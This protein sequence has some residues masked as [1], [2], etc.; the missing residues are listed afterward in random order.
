M[1]FNKTLIALSLAVTF[2][3]CTTTK[4]PEEK[5]AARREATEARVKGG[6]NYEMVQQS[7]TNHEM[8]SNLT[9]EQW[10]DVRSSSKNR[11][12]KLFSTLGTREWSVAA[13]DARERLKKKPRDLTSLI[14]LATALTMQKNYNLASYYAD[15]IE[16]EYP[17]RPETLNIRAL[18]IIN[19]P[20]I[21]MRD[22]RDGVNL[23]RQAFDENGS[24]VAA[25]L[26]LGHLYLELG[27]PAQAHDIFK[28]VVQRCGSC[29]VG[30]LGLGI[31]ASR[32]GQYKDAEASFSK[33]LR[34]APNHP[35]ALYRLA[36]IAHYGYN[37]D[38]DAKSYLKKLLADSP[39]QEKELKRRANF[40]LRSIEAREHAIAAS[41]KADPAPQAEPQAEDDKAVGATPVAAD[42]D[43]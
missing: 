34:K 25:G 9:R 32:L 7:N 33:V 18:A 13:Q 5:T 29:E 2:A 28:A 37:K 4:T 10:V 31:S 42:I 20:R 40:L 14:V 27:S 41:D 36:L 22:Y 30:L 26:N 21:T 1:M 17:G 39:D 11:E 24:E 6:A 38:S 12:L 19:R 15:L 23:L 43:E 16:K 8:F 35:Q 3:A